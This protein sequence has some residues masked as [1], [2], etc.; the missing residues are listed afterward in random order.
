MIY[1][2]GQFYLIA[3]V[4]I[5]VIIIGFVTIKNYSKET[6][7]HTTI[8]G[9]EKGLE[10][11][12]A[13][14]LDYGI[15]N[16][17]EINMTNLLETFT[18]AYAEYAELDRLYFIFGNSENITVAGYHELEEGEILINIE[19]T[20]DNLYSDKLDITKKKYKRWDFSAKSKE[21]TEIKRVIITID[22][23][24]YK[25]DLKPGENFYFIVMM[26]LKGEKY[27]VTN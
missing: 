24:E 21:I 27:V 14:V 11:E 6:A 12:S 25:F 15:Y 10:I 4:I 20:E 9:L 5:I 13:K 8:Y 23:I 16:N 17:N 3:A 22:G 2:K 18:K 26:Y 7:T 1:K 19:G